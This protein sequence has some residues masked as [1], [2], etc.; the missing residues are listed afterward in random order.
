MR[1]NISRV[2]D[3]K[4]TLQQ[5]SKVAIVT[6]NRPAAR[7]ALTTNMWR[8]MA[9]MAAEIRLNPKMKVVILRGVPENFSAGSDIK[10]FCE[11]SVDEANEAFRQME[12]AICAFEELAIPVIGA[13]DGPAAG[14]GFILALACDLRI[15][16]K[17]A[18][19]GIPVGR[20][21][22]TVGPSFMRRIIR[23]TGPSKA[24]SLVYLGEMLSA[25]DAYRSGLLNRLVEP[26]EL[27]Q[28][29]LDLA[30][31]IMQQSK[32]SLLS[33]KKA[34]ALCEWREERDWN[35]VDPNDFP[36]GCLAFVEKRKPNFQDAIT[37]EKER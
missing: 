14:A 18:K 25:D 10:E 15:G 12:K 11:M 2:P 37:E 1:V 32:A 29:V 31:T 28:H 6:I 13:I 21:G 8:E 24:K 26:E 19:M 30:E 4:I 34:A 36:E 3:G 23:L 7:N 35:Y 9:R 27:H 17:H 5:T 33:V 16:T 22:I 20:L